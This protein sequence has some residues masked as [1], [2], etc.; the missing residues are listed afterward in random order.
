VRNRGYLLCQ[1]TCFAGT[2]HGVGKTYV[3]NVVNAHCSL[4]IAKLALSKAPMTAVDTLYSRVLPFYEENGA[5]VERVLTDSGREYCCRP[6]QHFYELFLALNQIEHRRTEVRSPETTASANASTA[7]SRKS[8]S[9][10]LSAR[11]STKALI[12][13]SPIRTAASTSTT[14]SAPTRA[15]ARSEERPRRLC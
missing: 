5:D 6:L 10:W 3:Q 7:P 11:P 8:S 4:A 14:A 12:S 9:P 13:F 1:D 15:T 2:I